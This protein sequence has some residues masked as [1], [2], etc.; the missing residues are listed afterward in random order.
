MT[1]FISDVYRG[2]F[3]AVKRHRLC[4]NIVNECDEKGFTALHWNCLLGA[5]GSERLDISDV[6]LKAGADVNL[7]VGDDG[8]SPLILACETGN[9]ELVK[10]LIENGADIN[11]IGDGTTPLIQAVVSGDENMVELLLQWGAKASILDHNGNSATSVALEY[12]RHDIYELI[13]SFKLDS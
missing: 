4:E 11:L 1:N 13:G 10:Q 2:D 12:E 8:F 9:I 3:I 5:V 7:L 6:L